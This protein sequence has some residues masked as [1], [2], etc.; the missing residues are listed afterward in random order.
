MCIHFLAALLIAVIVSAPAAAE[1]FAQLRTAYAARNA[2]AAA[3]AYAPRGE[4][5]Y[6]YAGVPEERHVGRAAIAASFRKLFAQIDP[7][8]RLDLNFRTTSR[9]G[10]RLSG[11]YRLRIGQEA[12]YGRF[13]VESAPDG[14]ITRDISTSALPT[15]FEDASGPVMLAADDEQLDPTYYDRLVGRYRLADGCQLVVTRSVVRL[16]VRNSCTQVWRGLTR[17]SGREWTAGDR[18][19]SG[20]AISTY[21]FADGAAG[22]SASLQ[23]LSGGQTLAA[24]RRDPYRREAVSFTSR[25]GTRLAGTLYL[26]AGPPVRRAATVLIHGSGPQDRNG[27]ASIIAVMAD[28]L[29]ASGRVVLTYDKRGVGGSSGDWSRAGFNTLADDAAAGMQYLAARS[30]VD[31]ARIGLAG[32]SQAGWVAA[33]AIAGGAKPV[34]VLLLG[35]AGAAMTVAEQNL[36]NTEMR[37]RCA[38]IPASDIALALDQQRAFFAFVVDARQAAALDELTARARTRAVLADWLFPDSKGLD[39][40]S[41]EWYTT[42]D[43]AFDP[44]PIWRGYRGRALFLFAEHDDATPSTEAMRRL[45][46]TRIVARLLSRS[47]H[48]GLVAGNQCKAELGD[49]SEFSTEFFFRMAT[50][51]REG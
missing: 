46:E 19:L 51:A 25:D 18:V 34:D 7:A 23:V 43:P 9:Q 31:A 49:L 10:K 2:D 11:I 30:E 26:P 37:M 35:A 27:Y 1:P 16:F 44:I 48:L 45:L 36:Y 38:G 14:S 17:V 50:F 47:Q 21:R 22:A 12:N 4:V 28:A 15:E 41:G 40:T 39:R 29:S 3:A 6:R 33:A 20:R 42:L 13:E 32:S 5:I 8:E 24:L